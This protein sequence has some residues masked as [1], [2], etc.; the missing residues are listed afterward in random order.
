MDA[1][2]AGGAASTRSWSSSEKAAGRFDLHQALPARRHLA[3]L[4]VALPGIQLDAQAHAGALGAPRRAARSAPTPSMTADLYRAQANDAYW[5]GLFG[6]L[7]LPHLR[8][9]VWNNLRRAGSRARR[10]AAA[11]GCDAA[12]SR[13]RRRR[14]NLPRTTR[15]LQAVVRDD[16]LARAAR[17]RQLRAG[18]QFRRHAAPLRTS[19]TTTRS[20][21]RDRPSTDGERH[22]LGARPRA[23]Q[24]SRSAPKTSCPMRCRACCACD[25]LDWRQAPTA[26][27]SSTPPS[28]A[29]RY[30]PVAPAAVKTLRAERIAADRR[31]RSSRALPAAP[32]DPP[33][34]RACRVATA[35]A[36]ATSW[37][38]AA[39]P[40]GFG[41]PSI[42]TRLSS[43]H[44]RRP[45]ARRRASGV[46]QFSDRRP[47]CT[48]HRTTPFRN[49]RP[50]LRKSCR[51]SNSVLSWPIDC[52]RTRADLHHAD[53]VRNVRRG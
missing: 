52:R 10:G 38:T 17:T 51:P 45:R 4:P 39:F 23:L 24:A 13:L 47:R 50:D 46:G 22:R 31:L 11:P 18:A 1:A 14:A 28:A 3:Q 30:S 26:T 33:Q 37:P 49:P 19:T 43:T 6:G 2:G 27:T 15:D 20:S 21:R 40:C 36:A 48:A 41:Q 44:A 35:S 12:R 32:D 5:H 25:E 53:D 8:R 9:A 34:P 7:Y 16:G 42:W 29:A